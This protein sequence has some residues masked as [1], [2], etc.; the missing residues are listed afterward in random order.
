M[1]TS[2]EIK[3]LIEAYF[4][5]ETTLLDEDELRNY[6]TTGT[7]AHELEKYRA[8]FGYFSNERDKPKTEP[9]D[10][11]IMNTNAVKKT[12]RHVIGYTIASIAAGIALLITIMLTT[13]QSDKY[14]NNTLCQGTFVIIDGECTDDPTKVSQVGIDAIDAILQPTNEAAQQIDMLLNESSDITSAHNEI[15]KQLEKQNIK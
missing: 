3:K 14:N 1:K 12:K 11:L 6:F 13:K 15:L 4:N 8:I 9:K 2:E 7:V 10:D 5:G